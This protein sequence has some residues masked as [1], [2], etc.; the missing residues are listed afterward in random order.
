[1]KKVLLF[2]FSALLLVT[3]CHK[4][5]SDDLNIGI[6]IDQVSLSLRAGETATINATVTPADLMNK[7]VLWTS[8]NTDVAK[9]SRGVVTAVAP[10]SATITAKTDLGG[11]TAKC[12]V[13]VLSPVLVSSI[14]F[15]EDSPIVDVHETAYP[16]PFT[17]LP[18]EA[19]DPSLDWTSSDENIAKVKDGV[20]T[21]VGKGTVT[22]TATAR[23][24]GKAS[25]SCNVTV[26]GIPVAVDLGL[27]VKWASFNLGAETPEGYGDYF[28]WGELTTKDSFEQTNYRFSPAYSGAYSKYNTDETFGKVDNKTVLET[29]DDVAFETYNG[30]WRIPTEDEFAEL[31]NEENCTWTWATVNGTNG[32]RVSGKKSGYTNASIFLPAGGFRQQRELIHE[33]EMGYYWTASLYG[34]D[35]TSAAIGY[36]DQ[37]EVSRTTHNRFVGLSVRAVCE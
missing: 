27:S 30:L 23:D 14:R 20:L 19:T 34:A 26:L 22:I 7:T 12:K 33:G 17:V 24:A 32:Y 11:K 25:A 36:F 37:K 21:A 31:M 2:L 3:A 5:P 16:I 13:T 35:P 8:D 1:M 9:V 6:E 4:D 28:A 15:D 29:V 18:A 10:G